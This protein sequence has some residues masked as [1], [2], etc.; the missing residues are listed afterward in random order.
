MRLATVA[1]GNPEV[2]MVD[3][4]GVEADFARTCEVC[5]TALTEQEIEEARE[6]GRPFLC[7]VH[8]DEELPADQ[9]ADD[10]EIA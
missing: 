9:L 4:R 7:S 3:E 8:A 1:P 10:E 5:G 2:A 6:S